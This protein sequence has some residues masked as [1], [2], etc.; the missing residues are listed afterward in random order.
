MNQKELNELKRRFKPDKSAISRIYGCYVNANKEIVAYLDESLGMMNQQEQEKYL[1]LLKKSLS[2]SLGRNLIDVVFSTQQVMESEEHRL[3]MELRKS[4]LKDATLRDTFYQKAIESLDMGEDV[5]Y[6]LLLAYDAYDVPHRGKDGE[7]VAEASD[8]VF[9]YLICAVCPVKEGKPELS[10]FPGDNEF[11]NQLLGQVVAPTELGFLFPA[12]DDRRANIYNALY[13]AKKPEAIHQEFIDGVFHTEPP[14][15]A[16]EQRESFQAVLSDALGDAC[17]LD[18]VQ[19][20]YDR[21]RTQLAEHKESK[22]P[23][24]LTVS[25]KEVGRVLTECQVPEK[26]VETFEK[27]CGE[28]FGEDVPLTAKNLIDEGRFTIK[29]DAATISLPAEES[30]LAETRIIDGKKYLLIPVGDSAQVNG[31]SIHL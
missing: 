24:V 21:L 6:L 30:Y 9:S 26:A 18:V 19:V 28:A 16:A 1:G 15:S 10:Y 4:E 25:P 20:V 23:E 3:L 7:E 29:T 12:F 5:S 14:M 27:L 2:G 22:N 8:E 31:F 17:D 11:H 13:Y